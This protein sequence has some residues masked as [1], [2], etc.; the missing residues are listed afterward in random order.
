MCAQ[1]A[2]ADGLLQRCEP[3]EPDAVRS[4]ALGNLADMAPILQGDM[5]PWAERVAAAALREL[6]C[7]VSQNRHHAVYTL[8]MLV[9]LADGTMCLLWRMGN[10]HSEMSG[11]GTYISAYMLPFAPVLVR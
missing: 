5:T 3:S 7:S 4:S 10:L 6:Q 1:A 2:L 11:P 9:R 8:G